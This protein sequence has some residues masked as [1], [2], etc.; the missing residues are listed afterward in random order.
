MT[1]V[2]NQIINGV[3][4]LTTEMTLEEFWCDHLVINIEQT[5]I[6]QSVISI[7]DNLQKLGF[8]IPQEVNW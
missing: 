8:V 1:L 2:K 4:R 5:R 3:E 7:H 6:F